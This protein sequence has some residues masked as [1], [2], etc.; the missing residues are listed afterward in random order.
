MHAY[1]GKTGGEAQVKITHSELEEFVRAKTG[2]EETADITIIV[3]AIH[4]PN[5]PI[6]IG[7]H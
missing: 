2:E 7:P 6:S 1:P 4:L 5:V 3:L